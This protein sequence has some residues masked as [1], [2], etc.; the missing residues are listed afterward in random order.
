MGL[1]YR[2]ARLNEA[3]GLFEESPAF[4]RRVA[5]VFRCLGAPVRGLW[6]IVRPPL[7]C[8]RRVCAGTLRLLLVPAVWW[9]RIER[10][11]YREGDWL[12]AVVWLFPGCLLYQVYKGLA[13]FLVGLFGENFSEL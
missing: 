6:T 8:G 4:G 1:D 10:D 2:N 12:M 5:S 3:T 11:A 7:R 13:L 9:W